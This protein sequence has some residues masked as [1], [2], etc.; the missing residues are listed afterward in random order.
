MS[1]VV[2]ASKSLDD[3]ASSGTVSFVFIN[4]VVVA[5]IEDADVVDVSDVVVVE[6][7]SVV[8]FR[9]LS[10]VDVYV[11]VSDTADDVGD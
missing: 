2:V 5:I 8:T 9:V 4:S 11:V 1:D 7:V 3:A 6:I 10:V